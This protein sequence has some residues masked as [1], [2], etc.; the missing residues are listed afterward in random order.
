MLHRAFLVVQMRR[1]NT[2]SGARDPDVATLI[3]TGWVYSQSA[4]IRSA[5][6]DRFDGTCSP[7]RALG[8]IET[9]LREISRKTYVTVDGAP[10][11]YAEAERRHID[12]MAD[13]VWRRGQ[14]GSP[15]VAVGGDPQPWQL[16]R[17]RHHHFDTLSGVPERDRKPTD[18]IR[19]E[20]ISDHKA[21][22]DAHCR[23]IKLFVNK[24][25][26]HKGSED[27]VR[28]L[29]EAQRGLTID[30]VERAWS[31]IDH[32]ADDI[33]G[34]ICFHNFAF[35]LERKASDFDVLTRPWLTADQLQAVRVRDGANSRLLEDGRTTAEV[36]PEPT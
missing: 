21:S 24:H 14:E 8:L 19:P 11:D 3:D 31:C 13:R 34:S 16:S 2:S 30:R 20:W 33:S 28:A 9:N 26:A 35:V 5:A 1:E 10:Y 12:A 15:A 25:V 4:M 27:E 22:L 32:V 23:D 7:F 29:S 36:A 18:C 6:M 17:R